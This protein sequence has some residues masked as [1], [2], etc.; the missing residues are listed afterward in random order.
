MPDDIG[1]KGP[2]RVIDYVSTLARA[3]FPDGYKQEI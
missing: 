3:R 2:R 1:Q